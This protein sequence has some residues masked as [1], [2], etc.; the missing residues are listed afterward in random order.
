MTNRKRIANF[1]RKVRIA[2]LS[3]IKDLFNKILGV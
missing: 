3:N 1:K 2:K